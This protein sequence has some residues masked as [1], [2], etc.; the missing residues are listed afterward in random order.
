MILEIFDRESAGPNE[1]Y[2]SVFVKLAE[3]IFK[4]WVTFFPCTAG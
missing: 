2:P 1:I 3:I 4:S